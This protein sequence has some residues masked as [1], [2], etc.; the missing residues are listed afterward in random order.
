MSNLDNAV[1]NAAR[2]FRVFPLIPH[3]RVPMGKGWKEA[4]DNDLDDVRG[5]WTEYPDYWIGVAAGPG[6]DIFVLDV[7]VKDNGDKELAALEEQN[8]ALP[9]TFTVSTKSGGRHYYFKWVDGVRNSVGKN[10]GIAGGLDI[11]AEGGFV[12]AAGT[13]GYE[14]AVDA[15]V[16][17]APQWL[18]DLIFAKVKK[19]EPRAHVASFN[20]EVTSWFE[21]CAE[22]RRDIYVAN[23]LECTEKGWQ[24]P[25]W[26]QTTFEQAC[27]LVELANSGWN[28][29][30]FAQ[31]Y[32]D[33]MENAPRDDGF[34]DWHVETCWDSA[35]RTVDGKEQTPPPEQENKPVDASVAPSTGQSLEEVTAEREYYVKIA[36]KKTKDQLRSTSKRI[37]E[38]KDRLITFDKSEAVGDHASILIHFANATWNTYS[39]NE[40]R[41]DFDKATSKYASKQKRDWVWSRLLKSQGAIARRLPGE[42]R[43]VENPRE[44]EML[45]HAI[46]R[47][48]WYI[49]NDRDAAAFLRETY[50]NSITYTGSEGWYEWSGTKHELDERVQI[51]KNKAVALSYA[52]S[53]DFVSSDGGYAVSLR[54]KKNWYALADAFRDAKTVSNTYFDSDARWLALP[55]GQVIDLELSMAGNKIVTVDA[56]PGMPITKTLGVDLDYVNKATKPTEFLA[57]LMQTIGDEEQ[58]EF[59]QT[60]AGAAL[61]GTGKAKSIVHLVGP[62]NSFKSAYLRLMD[63]VFGNYSGTI[64]KEALVKKYGGGT[65]FAQAKARGVRFLWLSEPDTERTDDSFLKNLSGGGDPVST[66]EKGKQSVSWKAQC[67]L[68]IAA[69]SIV[70]FDTRDVAIVNRMNIVRFNHAVDNDDIDFD[71]EDR[72]FENEGSALLLWI[73]DGARRYLREGLKVPDGVRKNANAHVDETSAVKMWLQDMATEGRFAVETDAPTTTMATLSEA[74]TNFQKWSEDSREGSRMKKTTFKNDLYNALEVPAD[75]RDPKWMVKGY[76]RVYGLVSTERKLTSGDFSKN[77][78]PPA[79][80]PSES[81]TGSKNDDPSK[82]VWDSMPK[83]PQF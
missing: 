36:V 63:R 4:A 28:T 29:Y 45:I 71:L 66:E 41:K 57:C 47:D 50:K 21:Y 18:V 62:P 3:I 26:N 52:L 25:A 76:H 67:V 69:N 81:G 5:F 20:G 38:D 83:P 10:G 61:L 23:L 19:H 12:V 60:A 54:T 75:K 49:S 74:W 82:G 46:L 13:P 43:G 32:Q 59:L 51:G 73:I 77:T 55:S 48:R 34:T 6:S 7:D 72:I 27:N 24:G 14:V 58:I 44:V 65:N 8:G 39:L 37:D 35:V 78:T 31:A 40:A 64:P 11:R 80:G 53:D 9:E 15:E 2:G 68:H 1:A 33:L 16:A 79:S 56:D 42:G 70:K 30:T 17:Q 22:K